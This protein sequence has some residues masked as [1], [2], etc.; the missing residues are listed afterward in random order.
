MVLDD[1]LRTF[2]DARRATLIGPLYR[3]EHPPAEPLIFVDGGSNQRER[4]GGFAVGDGD[5]SRGP[6]DQ[7][8][9]PD[10]DFSDLAYVLGRLSDHFNE[11]ELLGFLGGRRDHELFNFG[12]VHHFL[13]ARAAPTVVRFDRGVTAYSK[14]KWV[15]EAQG[16]FSLAVIETATVKLVGACKYPIVEPTVIKPLISFGLSNEGYGEV[17]LTADGPAFIFVLG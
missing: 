7:Y 8:L 13:C 11:V 2:N 15:F 12:E 4:G 6:I 3:G 5:S 1:Y 17:I 10:K 14:G 9:S 16:T